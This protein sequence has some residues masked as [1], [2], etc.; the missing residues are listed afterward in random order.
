[1]TYKKKEDVSENTNYGDK[2]VSQNELKWFTKSNRKLNAP[3]VQKI[4]EHE[5][6]N[7]IIYV[8]VQKD[9]PEGTQFFY[10]GT[11]HVIQ[12]TAQ[13]AT[14][15]NGS[16]VVTMHLSLNTPVRDDIY[17]YLVSN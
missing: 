4:L 9:N 3:E 1:M 10:L 13:Q 2:F 7:K 16:P 5:A 12:G 6:T 17:R 14:M 8:F 11:A 15:P